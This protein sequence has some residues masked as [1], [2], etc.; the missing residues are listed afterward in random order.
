MLSGSSCTSNWLK[1][2]RETSSITTAAN[3]AFDVL[4][5][6]P[7]TGAWQQGVTLNGGGVRSLG[8][9]PLEGDNTALVVAQS[10][11]PDIGV[12]ATDAD[13]DDSNT[14]N[15]AE[16]CFQGLCKPGF[17]PICDDGDPCTLDGSDPLGGCTRTPVTGDPACEDG[18]PCT[19]GGPCDIECAHSGLPATSCHVASAARL[20]LRDHE[21]EDNDTVR[22]RWRGQKR[23]LVELG[24]PLTVTSYA[25]CIYD[26]VSGAA[27]HVATLAVPPGGWWQA[28]VSAGFAYRD[29]TAVFDGVKSMVLKLGRRHRMNIRVKAKGLNVPLPSPANAS[30]F[31]E[32]ESSVVVQLVNSDGICWESEFEPPVKANQSDRFADAV[33]P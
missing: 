30:Y 26:T 22:W 5:F 19:P 28:R 23:P 21:E 7:E 32:H 10:E 18:E 3:K 31:F 20:T 4:W 27:L 16:V 8:T 15:G 14:C 24:Q 11:E 9:T 6:S 2:S 17:A 29:K 13:C 33:H 12:C 1:P 25:L